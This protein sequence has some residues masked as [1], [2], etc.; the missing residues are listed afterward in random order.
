MIFSRPITGLLAIAL[1]LCGQFVPLVVPHQHH[2]GCGASCCTS[3]CDNEQGECCED[4]HASHAGHTHFHSD[5]T[6]HA[7]AGH[8]HHDHTHAAPDG[9]KAPQ[10]G[11]V[12]F[13]SDCPLCR[14]IAQQASVVQHVALV[15]TGEL[16]LAEP[17]LL[18][19]R[20]DSTN[21]AVF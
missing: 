3:C 1:Y 7:H 17:P 6:C 9:T 11:H 5:G 20:F 12:P 4:I 13:D 18:V 10:R 16:Y 19:E 2:A 15:E 14:L 8:E 21:Q